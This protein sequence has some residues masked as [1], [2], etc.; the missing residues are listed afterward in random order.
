KLAYA[1]MLRYVGDTRF[2]SSSL[3]PLLD[4]NA[5][6]ERARQIDA[7]RAA[8]DVRPSVLAGLTTSIGAD[9]VYFCAI[10]RH[11]NIASVIQSIFEGFGTAIVPDGC[12]FA[13]HNRG[14]LFTLEDGHP[15]QL[16]ARKRPLHTIIPAFM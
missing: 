5:A 2:V 16:A 3:Q 9:T 6:K 1:D 12:G 15:N 8:V 11:G 7:M 13:L 4:K 14:A 10:D